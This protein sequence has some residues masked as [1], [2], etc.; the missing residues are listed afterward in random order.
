MRSRDEWFLQDDIERR[1]IEFPDWDGDLVPIFE[2][3]DSYIES[4]YSFCLPVPH[5]QLNTAFQETLWDYDYA[6]SRARL[7]PP[8]SKHFL[9]RAVR[10]RAKGVKLRW[11]GSKSFYI[12]PAT[13]RAVARQEQHEEAAYR[14]KRIWL[15][16]VIL[17]RF[18]AETRQ[19]LL[20]LV[21]SHRR[22]ERPLDELGVSPYEEAI[23]R[24]Q[25]SYVRA[26]NAITPEGKHHLPRIESCSRIVGKRRVHEIDPKV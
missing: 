20:W 17:A 6:S 22:T 8:G 24:D 15:S 5:A 26:V 4:L 23:H 25:C 11:L 12:D 21:A 16:R 13:N 14:F 3:Q 7:F 9:G 19:V 1:F 2:K 18:L 10:N